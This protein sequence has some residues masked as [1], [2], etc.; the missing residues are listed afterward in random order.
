MVEFILPKFGIPCAIFNILGT[1]LRMKI[2]RKTNCCLNCNHTLSEVYNFCPHCGQ[3]NNDHRV[4]FGIFIGDFLSN[5]F[6]FDTRIGRSIQ[7]FFLRPGYLTNQFNEGKRMRYVHPLRLYLIVSIFFFFVATLLV[8]RNLEEVSLVP[9]AVMRDEAIEEDTTVISGWNRTLDVMRNADLSDQVAL[10]SLRNIGFVQGD[11]E[12]QELMNRLFH[13]FRKVVNNDVSLF[14]GYLMQNL[15]VM[16]F[17]VL[18]LLALVIKLFYIRRNF[19]YV[20]HLVHVLHLHAFTFLVFGLY[21]LILIIFDARETTPDGVSSGILLLLMG[22]SFLSFLKVYR[23]RWPKTLLKFFL[24]ANVYLILL[25][26]AALTEGII[27]FLI[28]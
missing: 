8:Q 1:Y 19:F 3:E 17:I 2:R 25:V 22:Y 18:P 23:Q 24:L 11:L 15:P 13:Q 14:S 27:S 5:Y 21:L 12:N 26:V 4:S 10:D 16:M 28:F 9:D 20:H 6:S 7:P